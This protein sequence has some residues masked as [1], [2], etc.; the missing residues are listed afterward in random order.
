MTPDRRAWRSETPMIQSAAQGAGRPAGNWRPWLVWLLGALSFSYAF[1]QRVSPSVMIDPLM[2]DLALGGAVLGNLSAFYFYVYAG[3]QIPIG[4]AIDRYGPR[5]TIAPALLVAAVGSLLF[6]QA[7]SVETAY[8]GRLLVG[9]GVAWGYV[10]SLKLATNWFPANR[11][12][13]LSGLTMTFGMAG[14]ILGQAPLAAL[15]E[16]GGWRHAL[17]VLAALAALLAVGVWLI[18]R[19]RPEGE[20]EEHHRQASPLAGLKQ[21]IA[22][23]QNWLLAITSAA[24]S[25]PMLALAG[26]WGVSWLMQVHGLT[27]PEAAGSASAMFIGWAAGSPVIGWAAD[28]YGRP[29]LLM[30]AALLAACGGLAALV[31]LPLPS[32]LMLPLMVAIGFCLGGMV[33]G[34]ALAR[35][36][37]DKSV[38]G[39]AIAFVNTAVTATGALFQPLI[40]F[41]LDMKWA[42]LEAAGAR[43]YGAG[44]Y[45]AGFSLLIA[46]L[47]LAFGVSFLIKEETAR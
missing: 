11:F 40:G 26:L 32:L 42:G 31:Y 22:S 8:M 28:R 30:Q 35:L 9:F 4:M 36:S 43:I 33:T 5:R 47:A 46:F 20:E 3:L 29:K 1:V 19:D 10:G 24:M 25:A 14:G 17:V 13:L 15:V 23:R 38:T 41:V 21:V 34:F 18:V 2:A 27:R 45:Q 12:A 39:S 6:S 16:A 37:N 44:A 7:Q